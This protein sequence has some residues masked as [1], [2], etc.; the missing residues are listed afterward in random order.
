MTACKS[1]GSGCV[2]SELA[3]VDSTNGST[4]DAAVSRFRFPIPRFQFGCLFPEPFVF[5]VS[6]LVACFLFIFLKVVDA[7]MFHGIHLVSGVSR[8][9]DFRCCT[10][11]N[12]LQ[13]TWYF[14]LTGIVRSRRRPSR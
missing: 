12:W 14:S 1:W 2:R 7:P 9:T 8:A 11:G 5:L 3:R 6:F 13:P 4:A 10:Q